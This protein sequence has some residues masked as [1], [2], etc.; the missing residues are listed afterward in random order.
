M[1]NSDPSFSLKPSLRKRGTSLKQSALLAP[2]YEGTA[3]SNLPYLH[4]HTRAQP[5]AICSTCTVI[6]RAQPEAICSTCTVIT[7]AQPE[8]ICSTCTVIAR[9]QPEAICYIPRSYTTDCFTSFAMTLWNGGGLRND[10]VEAA[11]TLWNGGGLR[12]NV[13]EWRRAS[14]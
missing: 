2:S 7:R 8:A 12:N 4:R 9:A 6:T 3:R 13:V 11:M 5:E 10:V 1:I 14:Q